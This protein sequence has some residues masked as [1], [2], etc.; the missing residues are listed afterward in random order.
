MTDFDAKTT[1]NMVG[2]EDKEAVKRLI[3]EYTFDDACP[4]LIEEE[5]EMT[6]EGLGIYGYSWFTAERDV[7]IDENE[8]ELKEEEKTYESEDMTEEFLNRLAE[9]IP[10]GEILEIHEIGGE[11][12][13]FPLWAFRIRVEGHCSAEFETFF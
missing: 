11:G 9:I 5:S 6:E 2:V 4:E 7:C 12:L 10:R 8:D 1:S 13:R 3:N